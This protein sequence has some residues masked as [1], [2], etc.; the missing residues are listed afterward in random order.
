MKNDR[1]VLKKQANV[2]VVSCLSPNLAF[3]KRN[4]YISLLN[5][6][7][8]LDKDFLF[9]NCSGSKTNRNSNNS[10]FKTQINIKELMEKCERDKDLLINRIERDREKYVSNGYFTLPHYNANVKKNSNGLVGRGISKSS[11]K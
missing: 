10:M 5:Y 4:D 2:D 8:Y 6:N 7:Y 3:K 1:V 11:T 9:S